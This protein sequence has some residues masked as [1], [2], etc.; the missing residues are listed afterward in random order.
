MSTSAT[1]QVPVDYFTV[2]RAS[3][4]G[5]DGH[6]RRGGGRENGPVPCDDYQIGVTDPIGGSEVDRV[7]ASQSV[8]PGETPGVPS[9]VVIDLD[10]V[11]LLVSSVQL[12]DRSPKVAGGQP[13]ETVGLSESSPAFGVDEAGTYDSVGAIP[14][15]GGTSGTRF[16]DKQRDNRRRVE[17]RD[18]RR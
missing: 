3:T 12:V 16:G 5:S 9:K 18:Q 6:S 13:A 4:N 10:D 14:E 11:E 15:R 7:V 2:A 1:V 17:I 8:Q